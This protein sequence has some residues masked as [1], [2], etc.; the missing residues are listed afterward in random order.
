MPIHLALR[1]HYV[2]VVDKL[3][4]SGADINVVDKVSINHYCD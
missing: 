2:Q 4:S 3:L 1:Y